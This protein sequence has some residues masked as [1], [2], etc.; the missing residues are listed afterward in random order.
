M[1]GFVY[2]LFVGYLVCLIH[3]L[4]GVGMCSCY[5]GLVYDGIGNMLLDGLVIATV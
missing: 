2:T 1:L 3:R 5:L 4:D